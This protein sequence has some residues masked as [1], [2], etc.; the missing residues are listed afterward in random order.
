MNK[1]FASLFKDSKMLTR[2]SGCHPFVV[3]LIGEMAI[4]SWVNNM[5]FIVTETLT[6]FDEDSALKRMSAT[7][8]EGRAFDVSTRGWSETKIQEF[9]AIFGQKY[10]AIAALNPKDGKPQLIVRHDTGRGDHFHIQINKKFM[11]QSSVTTGGLA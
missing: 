2:V 4:W 5:P 7:H 11:V 8:R 6:T 1:P 3:M 10:N 9:I